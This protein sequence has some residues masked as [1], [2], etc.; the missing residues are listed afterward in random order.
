MDYI[1]LTLVLSLVLNVVVVFVCLRLA[2]RLFQF[3]DLVQILANDIE[4]NVE[5][6]KKL[7]TTPLFN[8]SEEVKKA[9]KNMEIIAMRLDEFVNRMEDVSNNKLRRP[10]I[11]KNSNPPVFK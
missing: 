5:Y 1:L 9:N 8:N 7:L 4:V 10:K 11:V 2:R 3:D 6:F